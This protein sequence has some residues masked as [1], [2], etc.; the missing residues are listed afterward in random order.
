MTFNINMPA[1]KNLFH[2]TPYKRKTLAQSRNTNARPLSIDRY[3]LEPNVHR[4]FA[5][6]LFQKTHRKTPAMESI[7]SKVESLGMSLHQKILLPKC[8]ACEFCRNFKIAFT[9][10]IYRRLLPLQCFPT[11]SAQVRIHRWNLCEN[12]DWKPLTIFCK[13]LHPRSLA[14]FL[15]RLCHWLRYPRFL[16]WKELLSL[17]LILPS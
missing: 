6:E 2:S 1:L 14:E 16:S 10:N 15:I 4:C 12:R 13:K 7:F 8:F 3:Y 5:E 17:L 9:Y 11:R